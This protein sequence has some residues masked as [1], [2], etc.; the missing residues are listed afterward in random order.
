MNSHVTV[1]ELLHAA[2]D[3]GMMHK[4][5]ITIYNEYYDIENRFVNDKHNIEDINHIYS[6]VVRELLELTPDDSIAD[7]YRVHICK[8]EDDLDPDEIIEYVDVCLY[9]IE[10]DQTCAID[11][12]PWSQLVNMFIEDVVDLK[13]YEVVA[14]LLW[15]ITFYGYTSETM[16]Q[17]RQE[18][19]DLSKRIDSGEEK[20]IP[21]EDIT[22]EIQSKDETSN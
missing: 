14:H 21:W 17:K 15:E 19:H 4:A 8:R 10:G 18:L 20:L 1:R 6:G 9:D 5:L 13:T 3:T 2:L 11:L 12:T 16:D 22:D 7:K